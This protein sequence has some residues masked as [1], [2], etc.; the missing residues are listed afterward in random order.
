MQTFTLEGEFIPLIQL[1]KALNWVEHGGMA[2]RMVEEGLVKYNGEV[3]LRKRLKVRR[4]DW[5]EFEGK[6][7][8]II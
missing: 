5:I 8:E 7:V 1:L 4:G 2:Q 6:Q 3:D